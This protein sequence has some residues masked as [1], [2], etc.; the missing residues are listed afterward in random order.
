MLCSHSVQCADYRYTATTL[1]NASKTC[2]F[3]CLSLLLPS[4]ETESKYCET[5]AKSAQM[6][7]PSVF[8]PPVPHEQQLRTTLSGSRLLHP[9]MQRG[10]GYAMGKSLEQ[11]LVH[12]R[13][14]G[15]VFSSCHCCGNPHKSLGCP[16]CR[17][18]YYR[19]S[20]WAD[21]ASTHAEMYLANRQQQAAWYQQ[22]VCLTP[23]PGLLDWEEAQLWISRDMS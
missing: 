22:L 4:S 18:L 20:C 14:R 10:A 21:L 16:D 8:A 9:V 5:K 11:T 15:W 12:L 23:W 19:A 13:K 6:Q 7:A 3:A 2:D 1:G 17:Q